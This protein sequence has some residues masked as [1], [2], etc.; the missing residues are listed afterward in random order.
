MKNGII[1]ELGPNEIFVFGSNERGIHGAGAAKQALKWGA[2]YGEGFGKFGQTYA[3]PTK[4]RNIKTLSLSKIQ[5]YVNIF[6]E[7]SRD[8][9][10]YGN[11]LTFLVTDIGC[12][13]AGYTPEE[14]APMFE[15]TTPNVLL[16]N[17]F[18]KI[19]NLK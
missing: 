17:N 3:I 15:L 16:P 7:D 18:K 12:G 1:T 10:N 8:Y 14:I 13:L 2:K 6:L 19:L 5:S 11:Q 9:F 4:D